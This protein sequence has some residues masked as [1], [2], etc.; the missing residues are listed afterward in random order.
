MGLIGIAVSYCRRRQRRPS[1]SPPPD[2]LAGCLAGSEV[3]YP[4]RI[5]DVG[6]TVGGS[7]GGRCCILTS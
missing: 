4:Y 6:G 1:S 2:L 7:G 3:F 5:F